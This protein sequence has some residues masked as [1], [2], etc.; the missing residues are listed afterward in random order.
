MLNCDGILQ[1]FL[2]ENGVRDMEGN[3]LPYLVYVS[4]EKRAKYHHHKKGGAMNAF[5][6]VS[7]SL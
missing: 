5:G 7:F 2:G 3:E 1:V 4:R 6:R